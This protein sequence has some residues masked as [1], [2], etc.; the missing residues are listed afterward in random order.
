MSDNKTYTITD[1]A[2]EF[3][4]TPRAI[5]FYEDKGLLHPSRQ[6]MMRVYAKRDRA[7]LLLILRGKR[8]GFSLAEIREMIDLYDLGDGR[9]EQLTLTLKRSRDR[10]A[11][12]ETQQQDI[13]DA[14]TQLKQDVRIL[15][16]FLKLNRD[17]PASQ[18]FK[19]FVQSRATPEYAAVA[20]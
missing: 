15:D 4:V 6:G 9:M 8:L 12:L 7:R 1:L 19:E 11:A 13:E 2:H 14:I 10:L 17:R 16:D 20:E 3:K 18:S 5:R